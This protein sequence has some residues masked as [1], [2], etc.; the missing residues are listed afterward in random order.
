MQDGAKLEGCYVIKTDL[1]GEAADAKTIHKRY[2]DLALVEK[3]FRTMKSM[4]EIRPIF[5]RKANR[6]R[7]RFFVAMLAY[8]V[9]RYLRKSWAD[10]DMT[11]GEGIRMLSTITS[12]VL[13]IGNQRIV[14]VPDPNSLCQQLLSGINVVLPEILPH[15]SGMLTC[16]E[17]Y[18]DTRKKLHQCRKS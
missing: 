17:V 13:T 8:K 10:L 14:R 7:A 18:L 1:P 6:T 11:V 9:E 15:K 3:S 12:I 4:L 5:V 2:K 16:K